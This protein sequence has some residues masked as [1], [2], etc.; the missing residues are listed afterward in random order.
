MNK[1]NCTLRGYDKNEVNAFIDDI[2]ARVETMVK[3]IEEKDKKILAY[4]K[5]VKKNKLI[6]KKLSLEVEQL[7]EREEFT[8][9]FIQS[10]SNEDDL[11]E[12]MRRSKLIIDEAKEQSKRI[13]SEANENADIIINECLM[14]ARKSEMELNNLKNDIEKLKQK[15]ETLYYGS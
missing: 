2:I 1:F 13:I 15:K 11:L 12:A 4:Q 9:E 14:S 7:Q 10:D 8:R 6:I 3:E 5:L